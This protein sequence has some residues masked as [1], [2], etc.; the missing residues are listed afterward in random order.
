[1]GKQWL[2]KRA[3]GFKVLPAK[4]RDAIFDFVFL[5]SLFESK[6]MDNF[7]R[8]DRIRGKVTNGQPRVRLGRTSSM[9]S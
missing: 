5:W 7:A 6:V 3:P 2:A 1:M 4:D 8:A 9:M